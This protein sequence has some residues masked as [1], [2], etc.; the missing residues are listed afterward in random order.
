MNQFKLNLTIFSCSSRFCNSWASLMW[1]PI[2]KCSLINTF[3]FNIHILVTWTKWC[4][5]E[6]AWI[7]LLKI[8]RSQYL[9]VV[10][11]QLSHQAKIKKSILKIL[12][13]VVF[14]YCVKTEWQ[15][16][17]GS[18]WLIMSK[19]SRFTSSPDPPLYS[20]SISQ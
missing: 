13:C 1:I 9:E 18:N 6:F 16:W 19:V 20:C 11:T 2:M 17:M 5:I 3:H 8:W 10:R 14:K 4:A 12:I 15:I 7:Y